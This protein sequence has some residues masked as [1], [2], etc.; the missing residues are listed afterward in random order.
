M[1]RASIC[2]TVWFAQRSVSLW[3]YPDPL[4]KL[5]RQLEQARPWSDRRPVL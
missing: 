4:L 3:A 2:Q 5:A 1:H